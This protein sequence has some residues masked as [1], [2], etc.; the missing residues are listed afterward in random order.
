MAISFKFAA[1]V[2]LFFELCKKK[3]KKSLG[4]SDFSR[5]WV[6]GYRLR[7][8]YRLREDWRSFQFLAGDVIADAVSDDDDVVVDDQLTGYG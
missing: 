2:L 5:L 3:T 6:M 7:E 1:K 4:L 8:S